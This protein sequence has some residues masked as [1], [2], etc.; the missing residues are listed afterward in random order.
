MPN[1]YV[2]KPVSYLTKTTNGPWKWTAARVA[3]VVSA[4]VVKLVS[5]QG[6]PLN[7]NGNVNLRSTH[8]QT[9]VWKHH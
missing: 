3:S 5:N 7:G 1:L 9:N 4:S 2:G 8:G 6:V